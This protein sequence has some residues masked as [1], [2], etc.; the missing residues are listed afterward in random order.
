MTGFMALGEHYAPRIFMRMSV[1][2]ITP[3]APRNIHDARTSNEQNARI[4]AFL[5]QTTR[6]FW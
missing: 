4:R 1:L 3:R 5:R 2:W 6:T